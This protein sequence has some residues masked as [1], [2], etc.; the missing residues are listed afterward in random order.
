MKLLSVRAEG[1]K[2]MRSVHVASVAYENAKGNR[3]IVPVFSRREIRKSADLAGYVSGVQA[4]VTD[5][6]DRILVVKEFR[7]AVNR[8][9][10]GFPAGMPDKGEDY[11][12][13][14]CREVFEETGISCMAETV[15]PPAYINPAESNE[16]LVTVYCKTDNADTIRPSDCANEEIEAK[17]YSQ[18]ELRALMK[19][20]D[21]VFSLSLMTTLL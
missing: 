1:G 2:D 16:Q 19:D 3:K 12:C 14:A 13:A 17:F 11:G 15:M 21:N 20:T 6:D 8:W 4:I 9:V 7:L 5:K 18:D 10:Y